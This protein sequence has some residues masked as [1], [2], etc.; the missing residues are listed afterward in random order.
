MIRSEAD[1]SYIIN[2]RLKGPEATPR[3]DDDF[4]D[5]LV[6][7]RE[8]QTKKHPVMVWFHGGAYVRGNSDAFGAEFL[9]RENVVLVTGR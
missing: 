4:P 7:K 6:E 1:I 8:L 9:M 5:N 2:F 3:Q